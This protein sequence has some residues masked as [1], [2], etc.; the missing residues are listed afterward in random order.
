MYLPR[1][2]LYPLVL[3]FLLG[4]VFSDFLPL[5]AP[6][7][8][9]II[10]LLLCVFWSLKSKYKI[11]KSSLL[12]CSFF[13][14]GVLNFQLYYQVEKQHFLRNKTSKPE[15]SKQ[16]D[17]TLLGLLSDGKKVVLK[18]TYPFIAQE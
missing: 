14:A 2:I 3:L 10:V 9:C 6:F 18:K 7:Y 16:M 17:Q 8:S 15:G 13:C 11:G 1:S 4:G 12:Y 5:Q